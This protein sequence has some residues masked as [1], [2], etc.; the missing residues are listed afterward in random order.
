M[1]HRRGQFWTEGKPRLETCTPCRNLAAAL[2][3][4]LLFLTLLGC[5]EE[6]TV[7]S[8]PAVKESDVLP[9]DPAGPQWYTDFAQAQKTAKAENRPLLL[10][11]SGSDWCVWCQKLDREVFSQPVFQGYAQSRLV[12]FLA[13]FPRRKTQKEVV[14]QQNTRLL[15]EYSVV[16]F[17][18]VILLDPDGTI[19]AQTGYQAGG[20]D[21]YVQHL[22]QLLRSQKG[23]Q[24]PT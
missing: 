18:T 13:D 24:P 11:F 6:R 23:I 21:A 12:L 2:T 1:S 5:Q 9:G 14:E 19:I 15:E 7:V 10:A 8:S 17:P 22:A 16:G 20:A 4:A 3:L